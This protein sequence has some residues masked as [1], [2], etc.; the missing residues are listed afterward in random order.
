MLNTEMN[1]MENTRITL[2]LPLSCEPKLEC[3]L[4]GEC[5]EVIPDWCLFGGARTPID[6][7]VPSVP[8][9]DIPQDITDTMDLIDGG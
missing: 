3:Q 9:E 4:G 8:P 7:S 1:T 5:Y 2:E 6:T